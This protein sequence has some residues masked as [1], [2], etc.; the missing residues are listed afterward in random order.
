MRFAGSVAPKEDGALYAVVPGQRHDQSYAGTPVGF[1]QQWNGVPG[2]ST[3]ALMQLGGATVSAKGSG[4]LN[5]TATDD[6]GR[7]TRLSNDARPM[8][9]SAVETKR[10]FMAKGAIHSERF[11]IG[12]NNGAVVDAWF[13]V[14]T[15]ILWI[16][17]F[18]SAR[19]A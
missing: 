18:F 3:M 17:Q 6:N 5:V 15:A 7:V 13:E 9:L 1:L 2:P 8:L 10:D 12:F 11:G 4:S 19:R 14:H 16:R